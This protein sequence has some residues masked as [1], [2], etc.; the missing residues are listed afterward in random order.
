MAA[1]WSCGR[2]SASSTRRRVAAQTRR[3]SRG[4]LSSSAPRL[5]LV[6]ERAQEGAAGAQVPEGD[7]QV[8]RFD[9]GPAAGV[10]PHLVDEVEM[11]R[12]AG[13]MQQAPVRRLDE[14]VEHGD[15]FE[16]HFP[17]S[18]ILDR[19]TARG[20]GTVL[21][22]SRDISRNEDRVGKGIGADELEAARFHPAGDDVHRCRLV[23][24]R[25]LGDV[26]PEQRRT[27]LAGRL[28]VLVRKHLFLV[29]VHAAGECRQHQG[30]HEQKRRRPVEQR[31]QRP[32]KAQAGLGGSSPIP[33]GSVGRMCG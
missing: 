7:H 12:I 8:T 15:L 25:M 14:S 22:E 21:G 18:G 20:T 11:R 17:S 6:G 31:D 32:A 19:E 24:K 3:L 10:F 13:P 9:T 33:R 29:D 27:G 16:S 4:M 23:E 26:H 28:D 5:R 1:R 2:C 30:N